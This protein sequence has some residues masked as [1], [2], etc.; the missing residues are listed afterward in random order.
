MMWA[1]FALVVIVAVGMEF[2]RAQTA[3]APAPYTLKQPTAAE[4]ES[5]YLNGKITAREFQRFLQTHHPEPVAPAKAVSV[6]NDVHSL[7]LE[8]LRKTFPNAAA[9]P[10]GPAITEPLPEPKT[11]ASAT[12]ETAKAA[13]LQEVE[14]KLEELWRLKQAREQVNSTATSTNAPA[15]PKTKRERLDEALRDRK[16]V[17]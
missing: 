10:P 15:G 13:A 9:N 16:S 3:P 8:V 2:C 12:N 7:A 4:M 11:Q 1:R 17:V 6:T 14:S 5:L